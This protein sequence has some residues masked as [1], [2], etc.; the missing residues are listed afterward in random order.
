[1]L[2]FAGGF[3]SDSGTEE[4]FEV[5]SFGLSQLTMPIPKSNNKIKKILRAIA[6]NSLV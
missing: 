5:S 6:K 4:T 3:G 2:C 1:V